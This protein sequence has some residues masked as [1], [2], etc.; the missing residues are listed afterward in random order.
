MH[1]I[2]D[3]PGPAAYN[4]INIDVVKKSSPAYT[5]RFRRGTHKHECV[6]GPKYDTRGFGKRA[7]TFAFGIKHSQCA[8]LAV[9]PDDEF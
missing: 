3:I 9:T 7:P 5:M 6:P 2:P 4:K 1:K 8:V